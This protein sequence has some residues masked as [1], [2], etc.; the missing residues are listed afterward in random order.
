MPDEMLVR[1]VRLVRLVIP[2]QR[3]HITRWGADEDT[4]D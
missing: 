1:L 2:S 3:S 4:L